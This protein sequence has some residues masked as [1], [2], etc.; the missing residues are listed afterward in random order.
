MAYELTN[1]FEIQSK[2]FKVESQSR[3]VIFIISTP[4][5]EYIKSNLL[6]ILHTANKKIHINYKNS[7]C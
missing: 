1:T 4:I 2:L 3:Q 7:H 6:Q 5:K